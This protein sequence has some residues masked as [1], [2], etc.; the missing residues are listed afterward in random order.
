[1]P[2]W[3][4]LIAAL[5]LAASAVV[6]IDVPYLPQSEALCGGAAV[7]MVFRSWG[8][9]HADVQ[10][11]AP[12]VDV[13]AGGIANDALVGAVTDRGWHATPLAGS[14]HLLHEQLE[15]K[16]PLIIL[17]EDRPHRYHYV[18][19]TGIESGHVTI[20]DPAVGPSR[21]LADADL[22]RKWK[23]TNYWALLILP[24][25][26]RRANAADRVAPPSTEPTRSS[27]SVQCDR[28]LADAVR[29]V[30]QRGLS[31]ADI[32]FA[33]V[34]AQCPRSPGPLRELAG[35]R[36]AEHRWADAT[37]LAEQALALDRHDAYG[38]EVLASSRFML[39]DF[40]GSLDAWNQI[41][42]PEIDSV[43]DSTAPIGRATS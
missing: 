27:E 16:R 39:D 42:K 6:S 43:Q 18:V 15:A 31:S 13:R 24:G 5:S 29:Q 11:F 26:E 17:L 37:S 19:V 30:Q 4:S 34:R 32:L 8:D 36:F 1:M 21:R 3:T 14:L 2:G 9:A 12:L 10:Q 7:A 20:H 23:A 41:G 35:V 25:S 40:T 28:L 33:G 22:L 38:W